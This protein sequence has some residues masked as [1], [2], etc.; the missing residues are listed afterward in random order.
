MEYFDVNPFYSFSFEYIGGT[1][2]KVEI[3]S[4]YAVEIE[5]SRRIMRG[6]A[7]EPVFH[8]SELDK[9]KIRS[10]YS[11]SSTCEFESEFDFV[12]T[13]KHLERKRWIKVYLNSM[14]TLI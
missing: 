5:Y 1:E 7:R 12:I 4:E 3:F 2:F 8:Q 6:V 10:A 14:R 11:Y 13:D 9:E